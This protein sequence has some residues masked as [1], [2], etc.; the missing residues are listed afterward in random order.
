MVV[1][2]AQRSD[3]VLSLALSFLALQNRGE[4]DMLNPKWLLW[5]ISRS[6][7][8]SEYVLDHYW[9]TLTQ[10][11]FEHI[12]LQIGPPKGIEVR[13][14][15]R[16]SYM[17]I[18]FWRTYWFF[19]CVLYIWILLNVGLLE[20]VEGTFLRFWLFREHLNFEKNPADFSLWRSLL[21]RTAHIF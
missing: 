2:V 5:L 15:H 18:D 7:S 16:N 4:D 14:F 8:T 13:D 20:I 10:L 3:F 11:S 19:Y 17:F 6:T 9:L 1:D 21:G 12:Y